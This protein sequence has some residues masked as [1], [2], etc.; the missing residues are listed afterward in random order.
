MIW[1]VCHTQMTLMHPMF[2]ST[3]KANIQTDTSTHLYVNIAFD[4][5]HMRYSKHHICNW[6]H[7]FVS[8]E[9]LML[10]LTAMSVSTTQCLIQCIWQICNI[11]L[12]E[13]VYR[14][15][16]YLILCVCDMRCATHCLFFAKAQHHPKC[17]ELLR[18]ANN[19]SVSPVVCWQTH[20]SI[21]YRSSK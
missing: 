8:A 6:D 16:R 14:S 1:L 3:R 7:L 11:Q 5:A 12:C 10:V 13:L 9:M 21:F 19:R 2:T 4:I 18:L 20:V 17:A 15:H